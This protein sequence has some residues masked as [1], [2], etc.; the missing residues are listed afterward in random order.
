RSA[1]QALNDATSRSSGD[2]RQRVGV[3]ATG[4][5]SRVPSR[6]TSRSPGA[7]SS[8]SSWSPSRQKTSRDHVSPAS[9]A[10]RLEQL[11]QTCTEP[12]RPNGASCVQKEQGIAIATG[13]SLPTE[14]VRPYLRGQF[15]P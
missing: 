9:K 4:G 6:G 1:T 8:S 2:V 7:A 12:N 11:R 3:R 10:M 5:G 14:G 15:G 13:R